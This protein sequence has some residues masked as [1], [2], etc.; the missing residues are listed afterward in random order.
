MH[1]KS[2]DISKNEVRCNGDS[3]QSVSDDKRYI[4]SSI[5]TQAFPLLTNAYEKALT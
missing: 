2:S 3:T 1:S 5:D 4:V